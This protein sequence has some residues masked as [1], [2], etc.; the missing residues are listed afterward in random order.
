[1]TGFEPR[2]SGIGNN[3]STNWATTTAQ[4][5][6][7]LTPTSRKQCSRYD[8]IVDTENTHSSSLDL[9]SEHESIQLQAFWSAKWYYYQA[10]YISPLQ[11]CSLNSHFSINR[12]LSKTQFHETLIKFWFVF[13]NFIIRVIKNKR[14]GSGCGAVG[15]AYACD[16]R[17]PRFEASNR[18]LF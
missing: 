9:M 7:I 5:I 8:K 10:I 2:T 3:S 16:I 13:L 6:Q 15:R 11:L 18:H 12:L 1:M 17:G 4:V 14:M